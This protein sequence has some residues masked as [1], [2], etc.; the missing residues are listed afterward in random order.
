MSIKDRMVERMMKNYPI[1]NR[2]Y[3][4]LHYV[5]FL[6]YL[7]DFSKKEFSESGREYYAKSFLFD[8]YIEAEK[9]SIR[10]ESENRKEEKRREEEIRKK[11]ADEFEKY[12]IS[13]M[14]KHYAVLR[15]KFSRAKVVDEYG[16]ETFNEEQFDEDLKYFVRNVLKENKNMPQAFFFHCFEQAKEVAEKEFDEFEKYV[17]SEMVKHYA[18]LKTKF[19]RANVVD[20]YGIETF[21]EEQ[22]DED[23]KYFVRKVLRENKNMPQEFFFRCFEKAK[24]VAEIDFNVSNIQTGEDYERFVRELCVSAGFE[25]GMT[26]K[27]GDQ[28][29]DLIVRKDRTHIAIQCK[30]YSSLIGNAAVQEVIAGQKFY[31]CDYACVVS[32]Q[33][34]TDSARKLA[35]AADVKLLSH[36]TLIPYLQKL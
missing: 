27:T 9:R 5:N 29:V 1:L 35:N 18:V 23:L 26:P 3:R 7:E 28:G 24:E 12:V 8:C 25:C 19:N 11:E 20:E 36:E 4:E 16:I 14:V 6:K 21:N 10:I 33:D 2:K 22:F 32:N 34:Y 31:N 13:E 17:I 30:F 15:T